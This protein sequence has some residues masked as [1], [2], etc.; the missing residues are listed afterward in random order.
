MFKYNKTSWP[1]MDWVV[2]KNSKGR[3]EVSLLIEGLRVYVSM[4]LIK[5][6]VQAERVWLYPTA[7]QDDILLWIP[8]I[9]IVVL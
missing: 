1:N 5:G 3:V 2:S 6:L 8:F 4:D 9:N 7:R